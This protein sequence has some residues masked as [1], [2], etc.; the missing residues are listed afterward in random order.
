[1][2][3]LRGKEYEASQEDATAVLRKAALRGESGGCDCYFESLHARNHAFCCAFALQPGCK[4]HVVDGIEAIADRFQ[5]LPLYFMTFHGGS[6]VDQVFEFMVA[7]F[8]IGKPINAL[9]D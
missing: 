5:S 7:T 4:N 1:M 8:M 9:L 6:E 2:G 3:F